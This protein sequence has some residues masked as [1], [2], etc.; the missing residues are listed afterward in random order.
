MTHTLILVFHPDL[1]RSRA[2]AALAKAA[3]TLPGVEVVDMQAAFPD[4][5]DMAR[6]GAAEA[7][8]LLAADRIVLQ[9]PV[10]WYSAPPLLGAWQN[11]VLTRMFYINFDDEGRRLAGI[12][13]KIAAT[14]GNVPEAYGPTGSNGFAMIDLFTPLRAMAHRCA[15]GWAEPFVLYRAMA[16]SDAELQAAGDDYAATLACWIATPDRRAA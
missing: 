3:Q 8:R 2:N 16:L 1:A 10:Q 6:D 13:L 9:F 14:A 15:F 7:A 5:I 4:G 12:P 11:A